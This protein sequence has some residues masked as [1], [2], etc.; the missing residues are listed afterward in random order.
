MCPMFFR[1]LR[2]NYPA[3]LCPTEWLN[4]VGGKIVLTDPSNMVNSCNNM[5]LQEGHIMWSNY[6]NYLWF[7]D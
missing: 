5:V 3:I 1:F 7:L 2:Q 6:P 4:I